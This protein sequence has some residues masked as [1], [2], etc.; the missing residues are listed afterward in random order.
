MFGLRELFKSL[1]ISRTIHVPHLPIPRVLHPFASF[2]QPPRDNAETINHT[3]MRAIR[4]E[5]GIVKDLEESRKA[6]KKVVCGRET[7]KAAGGEYGKGNAVSTGSAA[8]SYRPHRV[9]HRTIAQ[10]SP[11]LSISQAMAQLR[12]RRQDEFTASSKLQTG[13]NN[14]Q[15]PMEDIMPA[16]LEEAMEEILPAPLEECMEDIVVAPL[17]DAM[18][19][20]IPAPLEEQMEE[21]L[22]APLVYAHPMTHF[23]WTLVNQPAVPP[24]TPRMNRTRDREAFTPASPLAA[25]SRYSL[26]QIAVLPLTPFPDTPVKSRR[27]R[28]LMSA[29]SPY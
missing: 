8:P 6:F 21:V 4:A 27:R 3:R 10:Q 23:Y 28:R 26:S 7:V 29:G 25:K 5:G 19:D 11:S 12:I 16:P 2:R 17:E 9:P 22:P 20:V 18:E 1:S 14:G 15:G 24:Q 13:L